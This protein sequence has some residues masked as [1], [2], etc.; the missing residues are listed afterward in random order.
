MPLHIKADTWLY[1]LAEVAEEAKLST[2]SI[3][4]YVQRGDISPIFS[5]PGGHLFDKS[6]CER[7]IAEKNPRG[8]P[9]FV[10]SSDGKA[11]AKAATL[12]KRPVTKRSAK[13]K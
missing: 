12:K 1:T 3:R 10:K 11:L 5:F 6:E 8:N 7:F 9:N 2:E 4:K 13:K